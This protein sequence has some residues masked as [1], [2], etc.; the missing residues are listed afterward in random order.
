[1]GKVPEDAYNKYKNFE[2]FISN[3]FEEL[4][5]KI[6]N[7]KNYVDMELIYNQLGQ[8]QRYFCE[9]KFSS[10][11]Y[12]SPIAFSNGL[13]QLSKVTGD[14]KRLLIFNALCPSE[15]VKKATGSN[16]DI[17][18][19]GNLLFLVKNNNDLY[20]ELLG[21]LDFPIADVALVQPSIPLSLENKNTTDNLE[22]SDWAER[23]KKIDT[24]KKGF[25]EYENLCINI[26]KLLFSDYLSIWKEQKTSNAGLYRFDLICKIK[27]N[28]KDDFFWTI[29][30]YFNTR[31]IVFDFKNYSEEITQKEV[32][33]TEKY[34]YDKAL[35]KVAIIIS[36]KPFTDN[37][38]KVARGCLR[39]NGKVIINLT[40]D[41]LIKMINLR[42][43][44]NNPA[45]YLSGKLDNLL[46][47]LEK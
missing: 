32:Y 18:D 24:G 41:D 16:I 47:E 10:R 2:K 13:K 17:I 9:I 30:N 3:L 45:D 11:L 1:M 34:L 44:G 46:V 37:A 21:L 38:E 8:N 6:K 15:F 40:D 26:L 5:C 25:V 27:S 36:R 33:T 42:D 28:I 43:N 31:Y 4:G 7:R 22:N 29:N 19:L 14:G 35:R 20:Q 23:L 39:E 12:I